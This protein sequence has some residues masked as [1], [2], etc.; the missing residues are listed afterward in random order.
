M[1]K[2]RICLRRA[3]RGSNFG[4]PSASPAGLQTV[5]Q[6]SA[7][8]FALLLLACSSISFAQKASFIYIQGDKKTPFYVKKDGEML[9]RYGKNFCIIPELTAGV[10]T[11]ELLFQQ[12]AFPAQKFSIRV[13][14]AGERGF[15][16]VEK[17]GEI[18]LYDLEGEFY[19]RAG[20]KAE[21]DRL[22]KREL[23][24]TNTAPVA[25]ATPSPEK[26][27]AGRSERRARETAR[28]R[29]PSVTLRER[30]GRA[31]RPSS[32]AAN[33]SEPRFIPNLSLDTSGTRVSSSAAIG[34]GCG[35]ALDVQAFAALYRKVLDIADQDERL[36]YLS[37]QTTSCFS[38][39]Q[40]RLLARVLDRDA[41]R[42]TFLKKAQS[43][44]TVSARFGELEDL[45]TGEA[46]RARFRELSRRP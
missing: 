26:R 33:S 34:A 6:M 1:T 12:N 22:P 28:E 25:V 40:L 23:A 4:L 19:L 18:S 44:I 29:L 20:N 16:I 10:A 38:P 13:P 37:K 45:L 14:E 36:I 39:T 31:N 41:A 15:L 42:F 21:E 9:P 2:F 35:E 43:S 3:L 7:G 30:D 5:W 24:N 17:G 11:L 8:F 32:E 27:E 46:Y